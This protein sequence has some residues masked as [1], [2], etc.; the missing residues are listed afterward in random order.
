MV[1]PLLDARNSALVRCE[2]VNSYRHGSG[3][4]LKYGSGQIWRGPKYLKKK[5]SV[6]HSSGWWHYIIA[7]VDMQTSEVFS[8]AELPSVSRFSRPTNSGQWR[9]RAVQHGVL[10]KQ[11]LI[12]KRIVKTYWWWRLMDRSQHI[13]KPLQKNLIIITFLLLTALLITIL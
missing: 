4:K 10:R 1:K 3:E 5:I 2:H 8:R 11:S 9:S 12:T 13:T 6:V 7:L